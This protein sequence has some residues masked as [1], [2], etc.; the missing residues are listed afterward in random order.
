MGTQVPD[1]VSVLLNFTMLFATWHT[2]I[3]VGSQFCCLPSI[4]SCC[5]SR[6]SV[7]CQNYGCCWAVGESQLRSLSWG[8]ATVSIESLEQ[9]RPG[10]SS[11][12][13]AALR[14]KEGMQFIERGGGWEDF[15]WKQNFTFFTDFA[16][17]QFHHST[18]GTWTI[19]YFLLLSASHTYWA[20]HFAGTLSFVDVVP[21][22]LSVKKHMGMRFSS[23]YVIRSRFL[24]W[25]PI[26]IKTM[27]MIIM[28]PRAVQQ[29][30]FQ[31][32]FM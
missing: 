23:K 1:F 20:N 24:H 8:N 12:A 16:R 5:L 3:C 29:F 30:V 21:S 4:W 14:T 7:C 31:G 13:G 6:S 2:K 25:P 18:L 11:A 28:S 9:D 10:W 15:W 27:S 32:T 17:A 26:L 19:S 22:F